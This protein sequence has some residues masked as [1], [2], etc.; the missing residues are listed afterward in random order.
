MENEEILK[1][2]LIE[3][4]ENEYKEFVEELK[5]K[6]PEEIIENAY[7]LTSKDEIIGQLKEMTLDEDE[8]KTM[9]QENDLLAQFYSDWL[10]HDSQLGENISY[11]MTDTI[12]IIM[13]DYN[14]KIKQKNR[15]SR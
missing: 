10:D 7:E 2:K 8:I 4:V 13:S 15:E 6:T 5:K 11:S 9:L 14:E 3:K 1:E 12:E